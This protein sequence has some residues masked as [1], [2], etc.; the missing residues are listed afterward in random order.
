MNEDQLKKAD[1]PLLLA[2]IERMQVLARE[3]AGLLA[4]NVMHEV[5]T[6]QAIRVLGEVAK[7]LKDIAGIR[8]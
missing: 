6:E 7:N 5:Q 8:E 4:F 1:K 2:E 3:C